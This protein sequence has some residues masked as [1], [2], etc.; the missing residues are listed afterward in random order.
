MHLHI[1]AGVW[2]QVLLAKITVLLLTDLLSEPLPP[3]LALGHSLSLFALPGWK[4]VL[5]SDCWNI[6]QWYRWPKTGHCVGKNSNVNSISLNTG[7]AFPPCG[8]RKYFEFLL[9][10]TRQVCP[11]F[12]YLMC[13]CGT[14]YYQVFERGKKKRNEI[15]W[16]NL[17]TFP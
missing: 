7:F 14:I 5:G 10:I 11:W 17:V 15:S 12:I 8:I 3:V 2:H 1:F 16:G 9:L 6:S 4:P 13:S